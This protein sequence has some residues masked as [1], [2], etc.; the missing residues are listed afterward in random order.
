MNNLTNNLNNHL[1]MIPLDFRKKLNVKTII[2]LLAM[3][4]FPFI[5]NAQTVQTFTGNGTFTVPVGVTELTVEVWGAGGAGGSPKYSR[6]SSGGG[7]GGAYSRSSIAVSV[8][9]VHTIT[10]GQGGVAQYKLSGTNGGNSWFSSPSVVFAEG[11]FG[12]LPAETSSGA[13]GGA[14]GSA[15]NGIGD[16]RFSGGNG[17]DGV[18]STTGAGGGGGS[19]AGNA[20][21]GNNGGNGSSSNNLKF[22]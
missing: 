17:G 18:T 5:N 9:Q 1:K 13:A 19:S 7:G 10:V 6:H 21:N 4:V 14:G 12:G 20:A 8:G 22:T 11:G 3:L 15:S 16:V 2:A